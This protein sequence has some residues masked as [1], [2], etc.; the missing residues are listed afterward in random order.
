[1]LFAPGT[2]WAFSD[3]NFVLLGE[4]LRRVGGMPVARLLRQQIL[5]PLGLRQTAMWFSAHI[6]APVLH[7][8]ARER[9]RYEDTIS[10]SP[11]WVTYAANMTSTLGDMGKWA[12]ALGAGSLLSP[13]SHALQIGRQNVGLGPLTP[14]LYYAMGFGVTNGWIATNPQLMGYNGVVS[15]LPSKNIAAV[16]FVTQG[17]RQ[18]SRWP[19]P[20]RST[21]TS[22]RSWP[23]SSR[24]AS[25]SARAPP[26]SAGL[27]KRWFSLR[28]AAGPARRRERRPDEAEG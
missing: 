10:W 12:R 13:A 27:D 5:S 15:Y 4:V 19:T 20:R 1:V 8:Y 22:Q 11:T 25:P 14:S 28:P 16:V 9:R 23:P 3:T 18:T 24:P 17:P 6:P 26:A 7:G 21:T 2:S